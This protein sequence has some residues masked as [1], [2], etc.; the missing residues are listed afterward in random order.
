[1]DITIFNSFQQDSEKEKIRLPLPTEMR[2]EPPGN[3]QLYE[4][5]I[6]DFVVMSQFSIT[7]KM[8][9]VADLIMVLLW[10]NG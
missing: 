3:R 10:P 9:I 5:K 7:A 1:M 4:Q 6:I 2:D 8:Y